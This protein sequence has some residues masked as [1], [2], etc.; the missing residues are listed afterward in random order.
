MSSGTGWLMISL[1]KSSVSSILLSQS[2]GWSGLRLVPPKLGAA[3]DHGV[4]PSCRSRPM[5]ATRS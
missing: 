2:E 5:A 1:K 4:H 3:G